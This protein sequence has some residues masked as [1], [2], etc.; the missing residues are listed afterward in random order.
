MNANMPATDVLWTVLSALAFVAA[1]C[2]ATSWLID[3]ALLPALRGILR[4]VAPWLE[5]RQPA[6]GKHAAGDDTD[7]IRVFR[8]ANEEHL[9]PPHEPDPPGPA[10]EANSGTFLGDHFGPEGTT[11]RPG[12][13]DLDALDL[14]IE[15][16]RQHTTADPQL[17]PA[18]RAA[19]G[20]DSVDCYLD[21]MRRKLTAVLDG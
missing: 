9:V 10:S 3:N 15:A 6:T 12:P 20:F 18:I 14:L 13:G 19:L 11:P 5:R 17:L 8:E 21:S 16:S 7:T 4:P 1:L 2:F